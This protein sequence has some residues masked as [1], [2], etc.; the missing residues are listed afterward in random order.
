MS[1]CWFNKLISLFLSAVIVY[2]SG[3]RD[4]VHLPLKP[5]DCL[6][7]EWSSWTRC[8]PC[9]K[10]RVR[11]IYYTS[12]TICNSCLLVWSFIVVLYYHHSARK[13]HIHFYPDIMHLRL[14]EIKL[15]HIS[16][17]SVSLCHA[18]SAIWVWRRIVW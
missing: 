16:L 2:S 13:T 9:L 14:D 6:M 17:I 10:K 7:S 15:V 12:H 8:D 4:A 3:D 18:E 1:S 11:I 5:V